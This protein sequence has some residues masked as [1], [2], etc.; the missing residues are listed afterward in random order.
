MTSLNYFVFKVGDLYYKDHQDSEIT[1]TGSL[2][3]ATI[4]FELM[5][6]EITEAERCLMTHRLS[7]KRVVLKEEDYYKSNTL[8]ML[9]PYW[10]EKSKP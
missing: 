3:N 2:S 7:Y 1:F 10:K 4:F 6:E 5:N 9:E 8:K